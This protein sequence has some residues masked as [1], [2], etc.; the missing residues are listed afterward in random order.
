MAE[1]EYEGRTEQEA[2]DK[3][4]EALGLEADEIDVEVVAEQ[5]PGFLKSG[6]VRIRVHLT[7]DEDDLH[8]LEPENE[9]EERLLA[10]VATIL[11]YASLP[12]EVQID[13]REAGRLVLDILSDDPAIVIGKH[14]STLES[15]Q[16]VANIYAGRINP[17]GD[18]VRV[19]LDTEDYRYRREQSLLRMATRVAREVRRSGRSRLLAP[20]NPFERRLVHAALGE[21]SDVST[22]SEGEGLYKQIR[23]SYV[24]DR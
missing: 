9:F 17:D 7:E 20:L 2:I 15:L 14:G 8:A 11:E 5:R 22:E 6:K 23:V 4:I 13:Q 24:G 12:A 18:P 3:A 19:V 1:R 16:L 10:Y 21:M